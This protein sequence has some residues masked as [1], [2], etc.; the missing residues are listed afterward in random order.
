MNHCLR[1][2]ISVAKPPSALENPSSAVAG[3]TCGLNRSA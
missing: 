3:E 1:G 2:R